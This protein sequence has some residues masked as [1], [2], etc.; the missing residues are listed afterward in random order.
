MTIFVF[1]INT[2]FFW[3]SFYYTVLEKWIFEDL[4]YDNV[5]KRDKS[6]KWSNQELKISATDLRFEGIPES[7]P[8]A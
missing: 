3:S 6:Y 1:F 2:S 5:I 7:L 4:F 8:T